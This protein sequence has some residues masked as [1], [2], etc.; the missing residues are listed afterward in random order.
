VTP[1]ARTI[2]KPFLASSLVLILML[3]SGCVQVSTPSAGDDFAFATIAGTTKNLSDYHGGPVLLDFMGVAC[4]PCKQEMFVLYQ[5]HQNFSDLTIISIDVWTAQGETA[6][7]VQ[8]LRNE[9]K[10]QYNMT[11]D[12]TFGL[13]DAQGSLGRRFAAEGVPHLYLYTNQG[14]LYYSHL[15]YEDYPTLKA[16]VE[17]ITS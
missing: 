4:P 3:T 11:L 13:D 16:K 6:V 10:D 9:F 12:W 2:L 1:A 15:G 17:A 7:D 8:E 5:L 14:N